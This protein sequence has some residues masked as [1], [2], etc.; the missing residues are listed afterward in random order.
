[1]AKKYHPDTNKDP[2]APEKFMKVRAAYEVMVNAGAGTTE[3]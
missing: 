1:M 2:T 3:E